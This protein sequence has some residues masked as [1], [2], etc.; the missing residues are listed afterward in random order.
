MRHLA[1]TLIAAL[2]AAA[3]AACASSPRSTLNPREQALVDAFKQADAN[4][5]EKLTPEEFATLPMQNVKFAEVD[6]DDNGYVT[7]P[8]LRSYLEWRHLAAEANRPL[9]RDGHPRR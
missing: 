7:L 4:G 1:P 6:S 5:D 9:D 3:L 8:E 2:L